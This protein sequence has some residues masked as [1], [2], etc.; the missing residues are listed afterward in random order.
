MLTCADIR[1]SYRS[2]VTSGV[3]L[4][5]SE[6]IIAGI[7]AQVSFGAQH[8]LEAGA[9][10]KAD[11]VLFL[12]IARGGSLSVSTQI[13]ALRNLLSGGGTGALAKYFKQIIDVSLTCDRVQIT[14]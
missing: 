5:G 13:G 11:V 6:G 3:A 9:I 10:V 4:P 12:S 8:R 7:G 1:I 14:D 2:G